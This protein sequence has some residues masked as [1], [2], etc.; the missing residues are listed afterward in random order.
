MSF[1]IDHGSEWN[2]HVRSYMYESSTFIYVQ[3]MYEYG[4][5]CTNHVES[6]L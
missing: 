2:G 3:I 6:I 5:T 1:V 4:H